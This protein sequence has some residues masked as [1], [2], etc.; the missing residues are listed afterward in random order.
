MNPFA[1]SEA[2]QRGWIAS[3]SNRIEGANDRCPCFDTP[4]LRVGTQHER[5]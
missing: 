1:L 3:R 2:E 4:P 5:K